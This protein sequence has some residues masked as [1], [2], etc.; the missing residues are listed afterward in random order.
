[1]I[2]LAETLW[3][4]VAYFSAVIVMAGG[5]LAMCYVLGERHQERATGEPYESGIMST[6]S[7][8]MRFSIQFY[9]VAMFFVVLDLAAAFVF[10][11]AV[12]FR[13]LGWAG[14]C[15]LVAFVVILA[16][17]LAYLWRSGALDWATPRQKRDRMTAE[18][19]SRERAA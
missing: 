6:G 7:A 1:M 5:I 4:L 14:Y 19:N 2:L 11:W 17:G 12:A 18:R 3:P 9:L 8:R 16:A 13:D 15:A 10:A